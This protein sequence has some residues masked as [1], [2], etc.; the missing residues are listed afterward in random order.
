MKKKYLGNKI[1]L[2]PQHN[3]FIINFFLCERIF[4]W[5]G[6]GTNLKMKR[7]NKQTKKMTLHVQFSVA[8]VCVSQYYIYI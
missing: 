1:G 8:S 5:G 2:A 3:Y 7:T 6:G 4:F